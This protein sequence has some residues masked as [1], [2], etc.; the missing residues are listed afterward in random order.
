MMPDLNRERASSANVPSLHAERI[1]R[2]QTHRKRLGHLDTLAVS[3][4]EAYMLHATM[5]STS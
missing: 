5:R 4:V 3:G 1:H 2:A